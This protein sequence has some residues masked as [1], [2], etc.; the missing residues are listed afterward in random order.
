MISFKKFTIGIKILFFVILIV[1]IGDVL[2]TSLTLHYSREFLLHEMQQ[3]LLG[4]SNTVALDIARGYD[5][6]NTRS[7]YSLLDELEHFDSRILS[8]SILDTN[9]TVTADL[10]IERVFSRDSSRAVKRVLLERKPSVVFD[11]ETK[12]A[13]TV[14]PIT[15]SHG[16]TF[17]G[18]FKAKFTISELYEVLFSMQLLILFI[19]VGVFAFLIIGISIITRRIIVN[20]L[21]QFQPVLTNIEKGD[22]SVAL[23]VK[24]KDEINMLAR[25]VNRMAEGLKE[26]EFV[27]DT[28]SKYIPKEIVDQLLNKTIRPRLEGELRNVTVLFSDIRG[29]TKMT[30]QLGAE[31]IVSILNRYFTTMTDVIISV[32]GMIDKFAGDEIMVV[33]GTPIAHDDDPIRAVNAGLAMQQS[34]EQLNREFEREGKEKI[35][36]GIGINSGMAI[37]GNIGSEKRLNY[38]VIGDDVNLASRLVSLAKGGEIIISEATYEKVKQHFICEALE[39]IQVKGKSRPVQT[40]RVR[41]AI[42]H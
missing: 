41:G 39:E 13:V 18:M 19:S 5:I 4:F 42:L 37:A 36:I 8:L 38:S 28:F 9:A 12:E 23:P 30:E 25:H 10:R 15:L 14:V 34:L 21:K 11:E 2:F 3:T 40:Y 24:N 32:E 27:K 31:Q 6:S 1:L 20:P 7:L 22:Y 35:A 26:R 33:F 17:V 29:F 16:G